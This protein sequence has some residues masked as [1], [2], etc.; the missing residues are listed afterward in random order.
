MKHL[1]MPTI[2][3]FICVLFAAASA[4]AKEGKGR[5]FKKM[6]QEL[7][8]SE[9]QIKEIKTIRKSYRSDLKALREKR[10][11]QKEELKKLMSSGEKGESFQQKAKQAQA[12]AQRT[13]NELHSK[14]FEMML[15]IREQLSP[16]QIKE[17][18]EFRKQKRDRKRR[19]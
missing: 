5:R 18:K 9:E 16:D 11:K 6:A 4:Q 7:D 14:R 8:L 3:I 15:E 2:A 10:K 17:F 1:S 12:E 19:D 13:G